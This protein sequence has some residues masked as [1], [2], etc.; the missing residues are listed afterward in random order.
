MKKESQKS[1][2]SWIEETFPGG[3]PKSPRK[4]IRALEEMLELCLVCGANTKMVYDAVYKV[5]QDNKIKYKS[6]RD[7]DKIPI[8]AADVLIVLYGL[9]HLTGFDIHDEVNKKMAINRS[10][11]WKA[12]GDGTGYHIKE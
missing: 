3:D 12:N 8:E 1:V 4:A 5:M 10:R 9:A 6:E 2:G 11:K 7:P